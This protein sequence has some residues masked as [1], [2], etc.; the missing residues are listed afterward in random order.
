MAHDNQ[1][2]AKTYVLSENSDGA[3]CVVLVC[4]HA[5]SHIPASFDG[6]GLT[7]DARQSHAAWDPGAMAVARVMSKQ[8]DA[9]LIASG[10][11]RLVYDCNRPPTATDAMPSRSEVFDVPGNATLTPAGR[12]SRTKTFYEPFRAA[13]AAQINSTTRPIIVTIHS[14]TPIYHGSPRNVEI[15]V[16]HDSDTRLADAMMQVAPQH[17]QAEV[18]RNEP[19]GVSDGV[20]HTLKEH[21]IK[22]GHLNVMLEIRNDLIATAEQQDAMAVMIS[23]WLVDACAYCDGAGDVRCQG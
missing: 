21:G 6:L 19:Y 9:A 12:D 18:R 8:L 2:S 7:V 20:T 11:S 4:E 5:S 14:F 15:G 13:L 17:S 10:V 16:L 1:D 3:S 23:D 22:G